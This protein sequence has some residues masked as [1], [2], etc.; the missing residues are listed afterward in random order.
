MNKENDMAYIDRE[1]LIKKIFPYDVVDKKCYTI[2]AKAIYEEIKN[3]PTCDV[4]PRSEVEKAKQEVAR[5]IIEEFEKCFDKRFGDWMFIHW[6]YAE[7]KKKYV[8]E[9]TKNV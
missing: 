7:L 1:A 5:E 3:A 9:V 2:N 6:K 4:V 8:G